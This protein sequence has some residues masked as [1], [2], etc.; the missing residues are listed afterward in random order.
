MIIFWRLVLAHFL[1]D[2]T[3]QTNKIAEWKRKSI[4]GVLFHSFVFLLFS[5]ILTWKYLGEV[6]WKL[7]GTISIVL[8][9][10]IHSAE[11]YYRVAKELKASTII[12]DIPEFSAFFRRHDEHD[13]K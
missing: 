2:F 13:K 9:A 8:L 4:Y 1:T 11:D 3:F 5:S 7:P 10:L 12:E 6:W